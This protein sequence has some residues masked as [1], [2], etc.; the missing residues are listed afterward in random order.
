VEI[1][2]QRKGYVLSIQIGRKT[3][4]YSDLSFIRI[5]KEEYSKLEVVYATSIFDAFRIK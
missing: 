2:I 1:K 5:I 4:W 3:D